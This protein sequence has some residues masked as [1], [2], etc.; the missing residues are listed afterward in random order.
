MTRGEMLQLMLDLGLDKDEKV[1]P[2]TLR[3]RMLNSAAR[4]LHRELQRYA[5]VRPVMTT[6]DF[7]TASNTTA[8]TLTTSNIDRVDRITRLDAQ[9][10]ED[11]TYR[12]IDESM[13][14]QPPW[15]GYYLTTTISGTGEN[16]ALKYVVNFAALPGATITFRAFLQVKLAD[17]VTGSEAD[18]LSYVAIPERYH[19]L[20]A[21]RAL[22]MLV[23]PDQ[24]ANQWIGGYYGSLFQNMLQ[25]AAD[26]STAQFISRT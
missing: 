7:V 8:Y 15:D 20:L 2:R 6:E 3:E 14:D 18:D 11:W 5:L 24:S 16:A 21:A 4:W 25:D 26:L 17:I 10:R 9:S 22:S 12:H 1:W 19:E 23:G 13:A